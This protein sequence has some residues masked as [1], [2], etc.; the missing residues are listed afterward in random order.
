MIK[1]IGIIA[2]IVTLL[3]LAF[4]SSI[5]ENDDSFEKEGKSLGAD[6][7]QNT[8]DGFVWDNESTYAALVNNQTYNFPFPSNHTSGIIHDSKMETRSFLHDTMMVSYQ[9]RIYMA[10]YSNPRAEIEDDTKIIGRWT[11]DGGISWADPFVIAQD[12][13]QSE[14]A[15]HYVPVSFLVKD[16]ILYAIITKMTRHDRPVTVGLYQLVYQ[17]G[18]EQ[19]I[20]LQ[21]VI[22]ES[23][24]ISFIANHNAI[25]LPNGN[26]I[27]SGRYQMPRNQFPNIPAVIISDGDDITNWRLVPMMNTTLSGYPETSVTL[28]ENDNLIA[29]TRHDGNPSLIF[30]SQD[31]GETWSDPIEN[32][33][34]ALGA[35]LYI[36]TLSNGKIAVTFNSRDPGNSRT[37]LALAIINPETYVIENI[38]TV[39][40]GHISHGQFYHYPSMI[41]K[42]GTLYISCTISD[43]ANQRS[44]FLIEIGQVNTL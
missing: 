40:K 36:I 26:Y 33:L 7:M 16:D 20:Y 38:Y 9:N 17:D 22:S 37:R 41:E 31:Y 24:N 43:S 44:A 29:V 28:D 14:Q 2:M 13:G 5:K 6:L 34:P 23:D 19:W 4:I 30:F 39:A 3:N 42:N 27:I 21:D 10:W 8:F 18:H 35:K 15:Y 11:E 32:P 25:L 1:K 12:D